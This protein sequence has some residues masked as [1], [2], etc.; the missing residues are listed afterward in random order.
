MLHRISDL[1]ITVIDYIPALFLDEHSPNFLLFRA[2]STLIVVALLIAVFALLGHFWFKVVVYFKKLSRK[3][4][5]GQANSI[6]PNRPYVSE[7]S[8]SGKVLGMPLETT[9]TCKSQKS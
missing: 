2:M 7:H 8:N 5:L 4:A 9:S 6:M 3:S 1:L